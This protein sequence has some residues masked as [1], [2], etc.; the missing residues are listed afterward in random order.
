[1]NTKILLT[2]P[3][4]CGKSTLIMEVINYCKENEITVDGFLT[5]EVK[6]GNKR[7]GFDIERISI[8]EKRMLARIGNYRT[9]Y[10]LGKYHV[11]VGEFEKIITKFERIEFKESSMV[12]VD[13][14]GKM[15]LFSQKFQKVIKFLFKLDVNIIATI[16]QSLQHPIKDY[17]L[18]LPEVLLFTLNRENIET[19]REKILDIIDKIFFQ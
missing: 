19:I 13:E 18:N 9:Q 5:P 6:R 4:R 7:I 10:R 17:L 14:I 1:M 8:N 3:P 15:E 11:F 2:G 12:V 16:G